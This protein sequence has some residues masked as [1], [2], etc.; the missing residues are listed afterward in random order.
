MSFHN[1]TEQEHARGLL[2]AKLLDLEARGG[3][4]LARL[5]EAPEVERVAAPGGG[6]FEVAATAFW[7]VEPGDSDLYVE[8]A[9]SPSGSIFRRSRKSG[10]VVDPY[11]GET[12]RYSNFPDS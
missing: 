11:T 3:R 2:V 12:V 7:D 8:V 1:R 6:S 10:L 9:V 5:V 4:N